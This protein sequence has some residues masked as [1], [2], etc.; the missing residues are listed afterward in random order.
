MAAIGVD[1]QNYDEVRQAVS[2]GLT[3]Y[4]DRFLPKDRERYPLALSVR[5]ENGKIVGG[6]IGELRLDY[7]YIDLL[8]IDESQRGEGA[9]KRLID[10][11]E[12]EARLFGATHMHLSTWSFQAPDF[13]R[14]MGFR[15]FGRMTDHPAGFDSI[16]FVKAF[17]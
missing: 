3:R 13:Y 17:T 8:W 12:A 16:F 15:E 6:L 2:A 11:A 5:D 14:A 10:L 4:N 9:G 7:L 1:T